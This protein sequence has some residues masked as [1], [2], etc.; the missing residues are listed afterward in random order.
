M[1]SH[2]DEVL[3]DPARNDLVAL[4]LI[5]DDLAARFF[6]ERL[7][8]VMDDCRRRLRHGDPIERYAPAVDQHRVAYWLDATALGRGYLWCSVACVLRVRRG[9]FQGG[10]DANDRDNSSQ[11]GGSSRSHGTPP[12]ILRISRHRQT[13]AVVLTRPMMAVESLT[14]RLTA[15]SCSPALRSY[16]RT[17]AT[18]I[19]LNAT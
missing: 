15:R 9:H 14:P 18:S 10:N 19:Q 13:P 3:A 6:I 1:N 4:E 7:A 2:G 12:L 5:L 8:V 11:H 16:S 17:I